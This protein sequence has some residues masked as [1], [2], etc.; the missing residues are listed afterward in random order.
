[1]IEH[2]SGDPADRGIREDEA[3]SGRAEAMRWFSRGV[4]IATG[5]ALVVAIVAT[6]LVAWRVVILVFLA[7]LLGS[8]LEPIVG[9][10]RVRLPIPRGAAILIV[11]AAFFVAVAALLLI[12]VPSGIDQASQLGAAIPGALERARGWADGLSPAALS[13]SANTLIDVV[14]RALQPGAPPQPGQIVEAGLTVVDVLVSTVT[15]LA[16]IYFWM[17]ERARLQRFALSFLPGDRR[18]VV[19]DAWNNIELRLGGWVRGQLLLMIAVGSMT[20][21]AC[22]LLGLPSPLLLGLIAGLAELI[23][24]V[25][26]AIGAIPA[27]AV[28]ATLRPEVL[29]LLIVAYVVIHVI[30][31]NVLVPIVMRNSVGISPFLI[32]ASLLLGGALDGLRGALL[33]VPIAASIEVVLESLQDREMPVAPTTEGATT[34]QPA[35]VTDPQAP[36]QAL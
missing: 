36:A 26:P 4:G 16:L 22:W 17:T 7:V 29:P 15:V 9:R 8:A 34:A 23:P 25:G 19:H 28:A 20:G 10:L 32:I 18:A 30:E 13:T 6:L 24:M 11:Y 31:G 3:T 21:L 5:A 2:A 14:A 33:A 27:V 1:M 12:V 35:S